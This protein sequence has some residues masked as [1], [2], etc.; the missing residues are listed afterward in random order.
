MTIIISI[1]DT[2]FF[3][4][5]VNLLIILEGSLASL[6]V[7]GSLGIA[8][9]LLTIIIRMLVWPFMASQI[10]MSKKMAEIKP[11]LDALKLKHKD[12]KQ[13]MAKAQMELY[14]EHGVNPAGGCIPALIQLPV[15]I[16]LVNTISVMFNSQGGLEQVN[17]LLYSASWQLKALPN[18]DFF[19]LNLA[20]K[21]SEFATQGYLLVLIPVLTGVLTFV[22]S[23]MAMPQAVKPYPT[24]SKKELQEKA[25]EEDMMTQM[26]SQMV[27]MM[28][29]MFTF[30]GFTF[31]VGLALYWNVFTILGIFQQYTITG[32]GGMKGIVGLWKAHKALQRL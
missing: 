20:S 26:Q 31:P 8:I 29:L 28:P 12:D 19:G 14:K 7:P 23:K 15:F 9:I 27:Y 13:A 2:L 32:W 5:I 22:Q 24:D 11:H 3:K 6:G 17:N 21:P 25:K 16:A 18:P 30:L 10:K 4:P 1:F